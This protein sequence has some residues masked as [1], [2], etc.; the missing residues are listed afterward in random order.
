MW[1]LLSLN[2]SHWIGSFSI[3]GLDSHLGFRQKGLREAN[4]FTF[5]SWE[6]KREEEQ[7][8]LKR[9]ESGHDFQGSLLKRLR[10]STNIE[11][12]LLLHRNRGV[13]GLHLLLARKS[14]SGTATF[15]AIRTVRF[16]ARFP[17]KKQAA[18]CICWHRNRGRTAALNAVRTVRI[19]RVLAQFSRAD[20]CW[21]FWHVF[22]EGF[23]Q[24]SRQQ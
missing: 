4:H 2:L 24:K 10:V 21:Y 14:R 1:F 3:V 22:Q 11:E 18:F 9:G 16:W 7:R 13:Y 19:L 12:P 17:R 15:I 6:K 20:I 5:H 8:V 23:A